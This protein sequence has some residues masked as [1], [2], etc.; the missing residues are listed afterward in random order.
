[1]I[2][3]EP[4]DGTRL[5][6]ECGTDVYA[7]WRDDHSSEVAGWSTGDGGKVWLEYGR[8]VPVTWDELNE[9]FC[10]CPKLFGVRLVVHTDDIAVRETWPTE[11]FDKTGKWPTV[12]SGKDFLE[13][14][15]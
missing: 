9:E 12:R 14:Q 10:D 3:H 8:T 13:E 7:V 5:E 6:F 2:E 11:V 1:M 15:S 4:P